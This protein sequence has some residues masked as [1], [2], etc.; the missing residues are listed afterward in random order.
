M[1]IAEQEEYLKLK[2][3]YDASQES[4][5]MVAEKPSPAVGANYRQQLDDANKSIKVLRTIKHAFKQAKYLTCRGCG[6]KLEPVHFK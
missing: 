5:K 2:A 3:K 6:A 4:A 1:I